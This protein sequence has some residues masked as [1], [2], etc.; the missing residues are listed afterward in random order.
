MPATDHFSEEK[1]AQR[2]DDD[3]G[4]RHRGIYLV[5]RKVF[6]DSGIQDKGHGIGNRARPEENNPRGR[7]DFEVGRLLQQH[8][9]ERRQQYGDEDKQ[10]RC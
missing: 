7:H 6:Q 1:T 3:L 2:D 10:G 8:L 5:E 9:R 4:D